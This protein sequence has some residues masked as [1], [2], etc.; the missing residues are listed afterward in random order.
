MS[1]LSSYEERP[2]TEAQWQRVVAES[3]ARSARYGELFE[4]L[5]DH[6]D[7]E[8]IIDREMGWDRDMPAVEAFEVLDEDVQ[9]P[10]SGDMDDDGDE[11]DLI[12]AY[13]LAYDAALAVMAALQPYCS[14]HADAGRA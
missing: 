5:I 10:A 1:D 6:P 12:P 4:T 11:R 3:D 8:A 2:P 13:R 9:E 7:R 14:N